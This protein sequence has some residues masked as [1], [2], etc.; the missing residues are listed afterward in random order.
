VSEGVLGPALEYDVERLFKKGVVLFLVSTVG[1]SVEVGVDTVVDAADNA[2]IDSTLAHVVEHRYVLGDV[3]GMTVGDGDATLAKAKGGGLTCE[4]GA[5]KD[6]V[7]GGGGDPAVPEEVVLCDPDGC[8]TGLFVEAGLG[9]PFFDPGVTLDLASVG[10]ETAVESHSGHLCWGDGLVGCHST[11]EG[12]G[13]QGT[14]KRIVGG[15]GW[16]A[17]WLASQ[18]N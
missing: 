14:W 8:E 18:Y 16:L 3:D 9:A 5:G 10:V 2:E 15:V 13:C 7:G 1:V 12:V 6:G 11:G 4:V 17:V